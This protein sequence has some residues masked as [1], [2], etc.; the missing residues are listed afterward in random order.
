MTGKTTSQASSDT[1]RVVGW[2]LA[3][4]RR[5]AEAVQRHGARSTVAEL[6]G[7][8]RQSLSE[9]LSGNSTP[10]VGTLQRLCDVL[11]VDLEFVLNGF[12]GESGLSLSSQSLT[13]SVPEIDLA[14]GMGGTFVGDLAVTEVFRDFPADWIRQFTRAQASQLV[15]CKGIGDSMMPTLLDSD[16]LL[17]DR[18][19]DTL[20]QSDR[21]W[22][23]MVG[24][25]GMVKRVRVQPNGNLLILSDNENVPPMEA[26][27]GEAMLIGRVVA[28]VR[29]M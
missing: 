29:K 12:V 10:K 17:V 11:S 13:L 9:I 7:I 1:A 2:S 6:A 24:D 3:G 26:A 21:I 14:Y 27:D 16:V 20:K 8:S 25:V 19:Q 22:V 5:L 15:L 4:A 28:I 18:S 23:V